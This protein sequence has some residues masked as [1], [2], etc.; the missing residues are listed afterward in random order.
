[1]KKNIVKFAEKESE[2]F[3]KIAYLAAA[4]GPL[5]YLAAVLGPL[6]CLAS[7]LGPLAWIT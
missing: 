4:L 7:A 5:A 2:N 6:A 1:M 3:S